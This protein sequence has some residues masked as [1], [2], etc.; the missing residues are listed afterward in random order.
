MEDRD[1]ITRTAKE[2]IM[3]KLSSNFLRSDEGTDNAAK[4]RPQNPLLNRIYHSRYQV[5]H[6]TLSKCLNFLR[7]L[8]SV[9]CIK[10]KQNQIL[11][12]GAGIDI[13]FEESYSKSNT[14][15]AVDLHEIINERNIA[16]HTA[17]TRSEHKIGHP[18]RSLSISI[19]GDL[20]SFDDIWK[21][22]LIKG[23][24]SQCPTVVLIECV[25]CYIDTSAVQQ[26]L[27]KLSK[28]LCNKSFLIMYD[29]ML[30]PSDSSSHFTPSSSTI[31]TASSLS[32][33]KKTDFKQ[34][35]SNK[36][37][38]RKAPIRHSIKSKGNQCALM[39]SCN[40][41]YLKVFNMFEAQHYFL[42][43]EERS[44]SILSEPFDEYSS[45]ALLHN[46]Y[47]ITLA[48]LDSNLFHTMLRQS[49]Q[50]NEIENAIISTSN[51]G[52]LVPNTFIPVIQSYSDVTTDNFK[53][54][55]IFL[56]NNCSDR[57]NSRSTS[58]DQNERC[59]IDLF[60]RSVDTGGT[61]VND[62]EI[63]QKSST[64]FEEHSLRTIFQRI[65]LAESRLYSFIQRSALS[66][67]DIFV[68]Y[69]DLYEK[70]SLPISSIFSK[71][72]LRAFKFIFCSF[73]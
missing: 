28:L 23:F 42:T 17:E 20:R 47:G 73:I 57:K 22:L 19:V 7:A 15:F 53:T 51:T 65:V 52:C 36:F 70:N 40:W 38:S 66:S 55:N 68:K 4:K 54:Q 37:E 29:P 14:I 45:L 3:C 27:M 6:K 12:L 10:G 43:A 58:N 59:Q 64:T 44:V 9:E 67:I 56:S 21:Q 24:D 8:N 2:A 34:M 18:S 26:L 39:K 48:G 35:M 61:K 60:V 72:Y 25:L 16:L 30:P 63:L 13:S 31:S 49:Y 41:N 69:L 50:G 62:V 1:G 5:V 11:I 71:L 46:L 32:N 33:L